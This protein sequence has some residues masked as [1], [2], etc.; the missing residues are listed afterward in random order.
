M[1]DD[2]SSVAGPE[3]GAAVVGVADVAA[4]VAGAGV[5]GA[6]GG[7]LVPR[8]EVHAAAQ[9]SERQPAVRTARHDVVSMI[10]SM[11]VGTELTWISVA[12][13][14]TARRGEDPV[15][16]WSARHDSATR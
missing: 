15:R 14:V 13:N 11:Q 4:A 1:G 10:L 12:S 2:G 16:L 6:G 8:P 7:E 5:T 9:A 3:D